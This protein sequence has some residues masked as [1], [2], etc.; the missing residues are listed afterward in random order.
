V[1]RKYFDVEVEVRIIPLNGSSFQKKG[2]LPRKDK[3]KT[4]TFK[5]S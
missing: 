3:R 2:K 5:R 4:I 1:A